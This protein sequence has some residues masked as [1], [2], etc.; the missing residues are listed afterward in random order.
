MSDMPE[1]LRKEASAHCAEIMRSER[2][3]G[4]DDAN[5]FMAGVHWLWQHLA[6]SA[7]E[8]DRILAA[9]ES[10]KYDSLNRGGYEL[11]VDG[12]RW[13]YEQDKVRMEARWIDRGELDDANIRLNY[14]VQELEAKIKGL[15]EALAKIADA[16]CPLY[17]THPQSV[18][19]N[20]HVQSKARKALEKFG[21]KE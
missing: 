11:F 15:M 13:M 5:G 19:W 9:N 4:F 18:W 17:I 10:L 1:S 16:K 20:S 6:N 8:F 2:Q 12:A 14:K 21:A 3:F 7:P